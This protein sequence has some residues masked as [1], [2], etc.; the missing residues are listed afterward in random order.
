MSQMPSPQHL[1]LE[2]GLPY[3][4]LVH[5]WKEILPQAR[6]VITLDAFLASKMKGEVFF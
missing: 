4:G 2:A 1:S 3:A 6:W 5:D